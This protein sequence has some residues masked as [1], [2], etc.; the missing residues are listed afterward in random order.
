MLE[1]DLIGIAAPQIGKN[2]QIFITEPR[3]T[4]ARRG[5]QVD[6]LRIYINP[7][8]VEYSKIENIIYEGCGSVARGTLFGP[9]K[10]PAQITIEAFD[11]KGKKFRL[12]TNGILGRV[13]QHE[14]DHLYGIEFT[15]K[16]IDIRK[17]IDVEIYRKKIKN[18]KKQKDTSKITH[19]D[20]QYV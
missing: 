10:R 15:E 3:K 19:I 1:K 7:K 12:T 6:K 20:F 16:L 14:Y 5:D 18:S 17:L 9:I 8:I 4:K 2:F 11:E 13:I